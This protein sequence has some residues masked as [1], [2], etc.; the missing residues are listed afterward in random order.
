MSPLARPAWVGLALLSGV[1]ASLVAARWIWAITLGG[2]VLYGE[3][4][5]AHAA[6]LARAGAEYGVYPPPVFVAASYTPL[7]YHVASLGEP[8]VWGRIVSIGSTVFVAA[9][10]AWRAWAAGAV[11]ALSLAASWLA[12]APV[13]IWGPVVRVDLLALALTV[14]AVLMA[15]R[16]AG[17][18]D[19]WAA[20]AGLLVALAVMAKP[21]AAL[22]GLALGVWYILAR[23]P[24]TA[25]A[26]ATG[27]VVTTAIALIATPGGLGAIR[28]QVIDQNTLPWDP[29][30]AVS[31][32][33]VG[34]AVV[35]VPVVGAL[36]LRAPRSAVAAYVV[37]ALGIVILGGREGGT[38]NYLLDVSAAS[39]LALASVASRL[40]VS[41]AAPALAA[42]QLVVGAALLD[43]LGIGPSRAGTG[44]WGD[45][46]RIAAARTLPE[47][48][49]LA[50]D[51]GLLVAQG[52]DPTV[53]DLFLWSRLA[54]RGAVD[55][56]PLL[57]AIRAGAF[58][59]IVS[60]ADLSQLGQAPGYA[61][62]RWPEWL[63]GAV[64]ERYV[65]E[66]RDG[67]LHIYRPR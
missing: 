59:R 24:R 10:I 55:R 33:A 67:S 35:G 8:F 66:R 51:S 2:P 49:I 31:L 6:L 38:I 61:R 40:S 16:A 26:Y 27:A 54:E 23:R 43:P 12:L 9:A 45:P 58:V 63:A 7:Y 41:W 13:A 30:G 48:P 65:L 32:I 22:P 34:A 62:Q 25:G 14:A 60:E 4:A 29:W 37:G 19:G 39:A 53:D 17:R 64:L 18:G 11:V 36:A 42:V 50:E 15:E 28:R 5:V 47:G 57:D 56:A 52:R 3:G 44:R 20:G 46:A 1:L 21:T